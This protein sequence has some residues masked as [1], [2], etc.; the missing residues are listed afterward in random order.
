MDSATSNFESVPSVQ[1]PARTSREDPRSLQRGLEIFAVHVLLYFATLAGALANFPLAVNLLFAVANGVFIALLFIIGHDGCHSSFVPQRSWNI[2]LARLAFVPC[3]HSASLWRRTHNDMHHQRT[4][5][6]GIDHV[7][8]PMSKA[9]YDGA[10]VLR[11]W[12]ER[13]YRGPFGPVIYYY[14]E[15]WLYRL[16]LPLAPEMRANWRRHLPDSV[17]VLTGFAFTL[18]GIG[19]LGAALAPFRPLWLT[20]VLG[21]GIPFAVWNYVMGLTIY[22]NHTHPNVPWFKDESS[23]SFHRGNVRSAVYIR[24][25]RYLAPLY[26][27]VLAHTAHHAKVSLPVYALPAAQAKLMATY[28]SEIQEYPVS[29]S[30]YKKVYT[31]CKLFDFERMCW[32]DFAGVPT[33]ATWAAREPRLR[34]I[35]G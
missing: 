7:W 21:W 19:T 27:D 6:K 5:L 25:P 29:L 11:R 16:V 23:W 8:A 32:T 22:L 15:F 13:V 24:F 2:W 3:V 26:S 31:A 33:A 4:N 9:E 12:L 17:F 18:I 20:F 10:S 14:R 1:H 35:D 30:E 34:E 28:E